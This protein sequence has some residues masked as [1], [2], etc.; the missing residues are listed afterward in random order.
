MSKEIK[1]A[2]LGTGVI[3][4][5]MAA[6]LQ[7]MGKSLYAVGNRTYDKA[8]AFA[9]K[10]G[11]EKIY[12]SIDEM[13]AD[14]DVDII[15][16]TTPHNTHYGFMKKALEN[17]K[18]I[19]HAHAFQVHILSYTQQLFRQQWHIKMVGIITR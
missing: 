7:K 18:H 13:F 11:I 15:Y 6:G 19:H 2:V 10:Y 9:E 8:V 4:N 12:P 3:A 14:E 16:I 17:G 5:E 1:W